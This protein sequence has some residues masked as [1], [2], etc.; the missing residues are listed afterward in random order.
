MRRH[1]FERIVTA[2]EAANPYFQQRENAVGRLGL[3]SLQ[4]VVAAV[5]ILAY[6]VPA[7]A[8]DEYVRIGE[9]TARV[10]LQQFCKTMISVFGEWYLRAPNAEDVARLLQIGEKRGFPGMLG[11][12]DCMHWEWRNCPTAW[13]G[14][15]TGRG[16]HPTMIL[17]AVA[18][19]DLWVWHAYFGM[20][21]SCNDINV[22]HRSLVF[23][24]YVKG[25]STPVSFTVNGHTYD[26]GYYLVDGIYPE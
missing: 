9:S 18:S 7:D 10:A 20:P 25:Q 2:L 3:S 15:F 24:A 4:K 19:Y 5:R 16:K 23:S 26:M 1:V 17:E 22:L 8:V 12:I 14:M 6:G 11:S 21:G 13:K